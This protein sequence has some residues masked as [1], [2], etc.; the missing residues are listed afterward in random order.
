MLFGLRNTGA[1]FVRALTSIIQ[2]LQQF[3]GSYVDDMAVGSGDWLAYMDHL[4][5]FLA[6]I[7]D[8]GL[9]LSLVK[10]EFAQADVRLLGHLVGSGTKRAHPHRLTVMRRSLNPLPKK[11]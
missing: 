4:R 9:T 8:A 7:R 1:T 11:R 5:R 3:A 10:C 6:T 2:L